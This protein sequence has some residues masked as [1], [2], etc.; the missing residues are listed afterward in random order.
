MVRYFGS[1]EKNNF[2]GNAPECCQIEA[3]VARIANVGG[4][5]SRGKVLAGKKGSGQGFCFQIT[6]YSSRSIIIDWAF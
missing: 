6:A 5:S 4:G 2:S 3:N 1:Y